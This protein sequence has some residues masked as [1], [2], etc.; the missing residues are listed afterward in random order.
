MTKAFATAIAKKFPNSVR[1]SIHPSAETT[2][3]SISLTPQ[4]GACTMTPW[5]SS[6]VRSVD[7]SIQMSHALRVPALTHELIYEDGRPSYFREKSELFNWPGMDLEFKYMYP[8]GILIIPRDRNS[9]YSLHN[10]HMQKVRKLAEI[11]S[12]IV[13]RGFTDTTDRRTFIAKAHDAG[14]VLPWTFGVLQEVKD[15][16]RKDRMANNVV[17]SEAMPMHYDGMFKFVKKVDENGNETSVSAPP[18]FQYFTAKTPSPT[19]SGYTL[20]ASSRLF[21]QYLPKPYTVEEISKVTWDCKNSGFWDNHMTNLPLVVPHPSNGMP[22][23]RW[24]EPWPVWKTKFAH[25][26][27][28]I[29]N[30]SQ[31]I[32]PLVDSLLY[33]RRVCLYFTWEKGDILVN[34]NFAML[35]TRTAFEGESDRELW[36]IHFD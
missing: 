8:C 6:L 5:H 28:S 4:V 12:P 14:E 15:A 35:H 7:G 32:I 3:L 31:D 16:G 1:L 10:V 19:G 22:C 33:D 34:D 24:H 36:R 13:L 23:V 29:E 18:R 20:F 9:R 2:K 11:C 26:I 17:S 21:F 27:I 25:C 30:A